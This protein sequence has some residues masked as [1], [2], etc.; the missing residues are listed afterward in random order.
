M[1]MYGRK[2][3]DESTNTANKKQTR[4]KPPL[5]VVRIVGE[6][7]AGT[8]LGFVALPVIW[9]ILIVLFSKGD[10][11]KSISQREALGFAI[12]YISFLPPLYVLGSAAGVYFV[13]SRGNETGS[14]H[15]TL[16]GG[17]L[18]GI[19]TVL[20]F[21]SSSGEI[22]ET[23]IIWVLLSMIGTSTATLGFNLTRKYKKPPLS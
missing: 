3:M 5:S 15:A 14:L 6:F 11:T 9:G 12:I 20:L 16:G 19:I 8:T 22:V 21:F 2:A 1:Y 13:G 17:S 7:V 4:Q 23:I 18:G 10:F